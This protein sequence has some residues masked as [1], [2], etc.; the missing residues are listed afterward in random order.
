VELDQ[1][2]LR[3]QMGN[4]VIQMKLVVPFFKSQ[5][6]GVVHI[7]MQ[8]AVIQMKHAVPMQI[9]VPMKVDVW[10]QQ[11]CPNFYLK[12][13]KKLNEKLQNSRNFGLIL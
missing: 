5:A 6:M 4:F 10:N 3:V 12:L 8:F 11:L 7:K 9:N 1:L 13:L 2:L